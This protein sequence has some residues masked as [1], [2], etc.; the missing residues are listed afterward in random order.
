MIRPAKANREAIPIRGW[1]IIIADNLLAIAATS[2]VAIDFGGSI[3]RMLVDE[4]RIAVHRRV[5]PN[6][7]GLSVHGIG[8][9]WP[10]RVIDAAGICITAARISKLR[11]TA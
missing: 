6:C 1:A 8:I 11:V 3:K 10:W 2:C 5:V 4:Y 7:R 9:Q